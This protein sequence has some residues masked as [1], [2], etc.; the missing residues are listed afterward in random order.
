M[1][2]SSYSKIGSRQVTLNHQCIAVPQTS[3][4]WYVDI[5]HALQIDYPKFFKMDTLSKMGFLMAEMVFQSVFS[6]RESVK[7][8]VAIVC[9]NSQASLETDRKYCQTVATNDAFPSPSLFVYTLPNLVAGEI[10]IRNHVLSE[11]SFFVEKQFDADCLLSI[12]E[13][14]FQDRQIKY[15]FLSWYDASQAVSYMIENSE[16]DNRQLIIKQMQEIWMN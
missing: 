8:Q 3:N 5:Y 6:D 2:I 15:V 14:S 7:D 16:E 12:A 13:M 11:T 1:K 10:A 9:C 4:S